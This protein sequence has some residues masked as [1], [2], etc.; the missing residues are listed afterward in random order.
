MIFLASPVTAQELPFSAD[1]TRA[2]L[3][4]QSEL[5]GRLACVGTSAN[6]CMEAVGG[7]STVGMGF[8]LGQELD[9]W[10]DRLNIAYGELKARETAEDA[11]MAEIGATV[12]KRATALRDM[13]RAWIA[14]RDAA[15]VYEYSQ[16]GGG[17]GGGPANASCL[18]HMT[19]EQA[20]ELESRLENR[21]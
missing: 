8:C 11:E 12:P 1:A 17:T 21:P 10:D 3:A 20:L 6:L 16:W 5:A 2:C 13:Q 14:W 7:Y 9:Y 18:M 19:A 4:G 15:C